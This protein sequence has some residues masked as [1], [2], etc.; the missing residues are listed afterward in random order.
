MALSPTRQP[1][2]LASAVAGEGFG[3]GEARIMADEHN[4]TASPLAPSWTPQYSDKISPG[5]YFRDHSFPV[6]AIEA[7]FTGAARPFF[8]DRE[9]D[10]HHHHHQ[11]ST[12]STSFSIASPSGADIVHVASGGPAQTRTPIHTT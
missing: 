6:G 7:E 3:E 12:H 2:E 11:V 4:F 1:D 8:T 5:T 10:F 9:F